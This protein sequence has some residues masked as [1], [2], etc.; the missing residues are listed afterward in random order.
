MRKALLAT[1]VTAALLPAAA[2]AT[3]G[4]FS[5]GYG[6]KAK[7]MGGVGIALPQDSLAAATNPAGMALVG[8]RLDLGL[9]W[10]KPDRGSEVVGNP[11]FSGTY[12]GNGAE[13]FLIPEFGYNRMLNPNLA[14]GVSVYGNGGMN[15][16][17]TTSPF[18]ALGGS[19]PA[20]VDLSQ[21]FIAPTIAWKSGAHAFGASLNLAYQRFQARG[22]QPFAMFSSDPAN[23]TDRGYDT[24]T[25]WG[26]RVGWTGQI[27]PSVTL[28]AT[29]QTK[30]QMGKFDKYKGLFAEQ[31]GFDIPENYG[32]G[33][34][35]KATP[36]LTLAADVQR[37]NYGDVASVGNPIDCLFTGCQLGADNGAGF[38]WQNTTVYKIGAMYELN[39]SWTLRGGF[40]TLKQPIPASQTLFNIVA[41]GVVE[42]HATLGATW[43]VSSQSELTL[44]YMHA[45]EKKVNGAGSI[46]PG[47]G[48]GEAN[49]RMSQDSLGIA[50]GWKY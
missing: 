28:G 17:Y 49:L 41:P 39:R 20:G 44:G 33:V 1:A 43:Q 45:F 6:I 46:P 23:L 36:G 19:S 12:D 24:S 31:G 16:E 11:M 9:D 22:L 3:T 14:L 18:A 15:T 37:I 35:W 26:V 21:L 38:G 34:A 7:S 50:W 13:S 8:N 47:L 40:T 29:Y 4:Y 25:G 27:T 10:F 32:V 2:F 5:H 48:G 42:N 30:T